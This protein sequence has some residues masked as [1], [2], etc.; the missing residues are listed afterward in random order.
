MIGPIIMSASN[1]PLITGLK[2]YCSCEI[3]GRARTRIE[4]PPK[5]GC[6]NPEWNTVSEV[7]SFREGN[8]LLFRVHS[9]D[10]FLGQAILRHGDLFPSG[11]IG[12]V[13]LESP[14]AASPDA[15]Q[16]L[17]SLCVTLPNHEMPGIRLRI[18]KDA[19]QIGMHIVPEM[20]KDALSIRKII[21]G[22]LVQ[23]WNAE[24]PMR[25][26]KRCDRIVEVNGQRGTC[27]DLLTELAESKGE[28]E[29]L[30]KRSMPLS[31]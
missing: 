26:I 28:V 6:C 5:E 24:N 12:D 25:Q 21:E 7:P 14:S 30:V 11:F 22:G 17:L 29:M 9:K 13:P 19:G 8:E 16:A 31:L 23:Q 18:D 10:K 27:R 1:F 15:S 20:Q 2:P 3:L 4:T